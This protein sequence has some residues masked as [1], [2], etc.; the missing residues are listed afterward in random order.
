MFILEA[1]LVKKCHTTPQFLAAVG[2]GRSSP[3][4]D[5][6]H[7][8]SF[9]PGKNWQGDNLTQFCIVSNGKSFIVVPLATP[10]FL[11]KWPK[12]LNRFWRTQ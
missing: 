1:S 2:K 12:P 10:D 9:I 7:F 11:N 4:H 6:I 3:L 5:M 8:V